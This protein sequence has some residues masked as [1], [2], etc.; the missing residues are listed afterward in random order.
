MEGEGDRGIQC[1]LESPKDDGDRLHSLC[2][3]RI[4]DKTPTLNSPWPG[5]EALAP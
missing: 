2:A 1:R 5:A 4:A 3:E